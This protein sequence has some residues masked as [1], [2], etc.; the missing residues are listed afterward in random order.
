MCSVSVDVYWFLKFIRK[1]KGHNLKIVND[2][3]LVKKQPNINWQKKNHHNIY[4][5]IS[6]VRIETGS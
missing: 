1:K 5:Q 3:A 6:I 2:F 4:A